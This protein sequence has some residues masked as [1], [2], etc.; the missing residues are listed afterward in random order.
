MMGDCVPHVSSMETEN[1]WTLLIWRVK[2]VPSTLLQKWLHLRFLK[3]SFSWVHYLWPATSCRN[4]VWPPH[5]RGHLEVPFCILFGLVFLIA[6]A[7]WLG[8]GGVLSSCSGVQ[9]SSGLEVLQ[10]TRA[11]CGLSGELVGEAALSYF[12]ILLGVFLVAL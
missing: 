4:V 9:C 6:P 10:G 12:Y 11:P 1:S 5:R 7:D 2:S 3:C 8:S